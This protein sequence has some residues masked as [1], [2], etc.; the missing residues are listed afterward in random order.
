MVNGES[1][2]MSVFPE[3]ER[4]KVTSKPIRMAFP[5]GAVALGYNGTEPGQ[6]RGPQFDAA[7]VDELAKFRYGRETWD[8]LQFA[9]RLGPEPRAVVTTTPR[10]VAVLKAI[11]KNPSSV[12]SHAPTEANRANLA[13]S[14][15]SEMQ[16][17]YGGT[18]RGLEELDGVLLE[19]A[20]GALWSQALIARAHSGAQ[21]GAQGAA[22][23]GLPKTHDF[24]R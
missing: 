2:I 8:M 5:N 1:G 7:W 21:T 19:D 13:A 6:L 10:N 12:V 4:P 23:R 22:A 16:A 11:L 9:L 24:S 15:L 14:F 18:R 3:A 17:R 20:E